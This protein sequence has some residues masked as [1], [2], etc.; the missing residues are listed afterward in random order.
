MP[1]QPVYESDASDTFYQNL[2]WIN[3]NIEIHM[4]N[5]YM[6]K[7]PYFICALFSIILISEM[8]FIENLGQFQVSEFTYRLV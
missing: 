6:N 1:C 7:V 4:V 3:F 5:I 2:N 8:G